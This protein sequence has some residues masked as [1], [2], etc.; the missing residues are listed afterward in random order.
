[1][2][3]SG[4]IMILLGVLIM[5]P[6]HVSANVVQVTYSDF[7]KDNT[8][9][10]VS[11]TSTISTCPPGVVC[12]S[13]PSLR[14]R[15]SVPSFDTSLGSLI[16]ATLSIDAAL[17]LNFVDH[18]G[19]Q[20]RLRF[21]VEIGHNV[22]S[23]VRLS[24]S[25]N[26]D[27]ALTLA[28][29]GDFLQSD[30]GKFI[31]LSHGPYQ[32]SNDGLVLV[33]RPCVLNVC[34]PPKKLQLEPYVE[35]S[36]ELSQAK[37]FEYTFQEGQLD[38]FLSED[39]TLYTPSSSSYLQLSGD[40]WDGLIG[41]AL[42]SFLTFPTEPSSGSTKPGIG[43]AAITAARLLNL[44][45]EEQTGH[46]IYYSDMHIATAAEIGMSV[47]YTYQQAVPEGSSL[48]IALIGLVGLLGFRYQ[49][50]TC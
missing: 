40:H 18:A 31:E 33:P 29:E 37:N 38:A 27:E 3:Q 35:N 26:L 12:L 50:T 25:S 10:T 32:N 16:S 47:T 20:I 13:T 1:M 34:L 44:V 41:G 19:Y 5:M 8:G 42:G 43:S 21:P 39:L 36:K 2:N 4:A 14:T 7:D 30:N 22:K 49:E 28:G 15:L 23:S 45:V 17:A 9:T 48:A 6:G 24:A 46:G 11:G